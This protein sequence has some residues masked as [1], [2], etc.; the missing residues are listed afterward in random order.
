[1]EE[2]ICVRSVLHVATQVSGRRPSTPAGMLVPTSGRKPPSHIWKGE[3]DYPGA[4]TSHCHWPHAS[5]VGAVLSRSLT[6]TTRPRRS[7]V[8]AKL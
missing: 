2:R 6:S 4:A 3:P 8:S 1:M 5:V 7:P